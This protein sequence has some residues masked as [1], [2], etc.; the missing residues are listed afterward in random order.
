MAAKAGRSMFGAVDE[1]AQSFCH[2]RIG[3]PGIEL[4]QV[5]EQA[6][7]G[8]LTTAL[9]TRSETHALT[10]SIGGAGS[11]KTTCTCSAISSMDR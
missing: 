9:S 3:L 5:P 11:E 2:L 6:E 4:D 10:S 8:Y 1:I 7:A